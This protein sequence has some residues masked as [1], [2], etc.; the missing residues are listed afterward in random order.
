M[1]K[2]KVL[3]FVSV[4]SSVDWKNETFPPLSTPHLSHFL[5]LDMKLLDIWKELEIKL[6]LT[7]KRK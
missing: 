1:M 7:Q 4:L 2:A 3:Y 5:L 6:H